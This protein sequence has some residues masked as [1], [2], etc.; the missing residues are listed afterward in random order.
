MF[1]F[2]LNF[3]NREMKKLQ[4]FLKLAAK[5]IYFEQLCTAAPSTFSDKWVLV[6]YNTMYMKVLSTKYTWSG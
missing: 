2:I 6:L 5:M 4:C 3:L 1:N